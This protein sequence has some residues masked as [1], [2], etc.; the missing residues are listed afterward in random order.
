MWIDVPSLVHFDQLFEFLW[1]RI[2]NMQ[3]NKV[4]N[5]FTNWRQ[6]IKIWQEYST[7]QNVNYRIET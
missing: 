5:D 4:N 7:I 3:K 2:E 1:P 6:L